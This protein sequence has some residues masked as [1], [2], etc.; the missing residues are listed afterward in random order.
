[1]QPVPESFLDQKMTQDWMIFSDM[2]EIKNG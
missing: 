2:V 1:M